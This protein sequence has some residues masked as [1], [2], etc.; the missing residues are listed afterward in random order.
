VASIIVGLVILAAGPA[1]AADLY[2]TTC[3]N[4]SGTVT[5][6]PVDSEIDVTLGGMPG[7]S[8]NGDRREH[9]RISQGL[10]DALN[11][12]TASASAPSIQLRVEPQDVVSGTSANF[13]VAD[14][15]AGDPGLHL[16][17]YLPAPLFS[18][19][20]NGFYKLFR[21]VNVNA[22]LA[23]QPELTVYR[24]APGTTVVVG[25]SVVEYEHFDEP[26]GM[27]TRYFRECVQPEGDELA[28]LVPHGGRI[29]VDISEEMPD[30]LSAFQTY[31]P[32]V[33]EAAGRWSDSTFE[34]WHITSTALHRKSFAGL[35]RLMDANSYK[36]A[37]SLHGRAKAGNGVV[38]GGGS[39]LQIKCFVVHA[40]ETELGANSPAVDVSY[41]IFD[42]DETF[43]DVAGPVTMTD[44]V[45]FAGLDA[46]NIVN[47]VAPAAP[48]AGGIQLEIYS[49]LRGSATD[50]P[51]FL[52]ALANAME[53]LIDEQLAGDPATDYCALL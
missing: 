37:L 13:T 31:A 6:D 50:F 46:D 25:N 41:R 45:E 36:Y 42:T 12:T 38:V 35:D 28:V 1:Q 52:D 30:F 51:A 48:G 26:S 16:D 27:N 21:N 47:R 49:G 43:M 32:S 19:E 2:D 7:V 5:S 14:I 39:S 40:I 17:V 8:D 23:L 15:D 11:I 29:E 34:Q 9:V 22:T 18:D 4:L 10:A 24:S 20:D 33:W 44:G 53:D 3:A